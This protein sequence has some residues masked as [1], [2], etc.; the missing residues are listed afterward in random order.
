VYS[1]KQRGRWLER[2]PAGAS[3][4][5]AELLHDQLEQLRGL[6]RKARRELLGESRKQ[7]VAARLREIPGLGPVRVALLIAAMQTP[8][9]FRT[10]RK[11]W[12]Y[13]GLGL[14][15]KGS[16]EYR[17]VEGRAVRRDRA[18]HPRG[19]N[20][21]HRPGLKEIFKSAALAAIRQPGPFKDYYEPRV[22]QGA[23][24]AILRVSVARKLAALTL[25]LWKKGGRY[26]AEGV[27]QA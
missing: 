9:R 5:R 6:R 7:Q 19:L 23:N 20:R 10:R 18:L 25:S 8:H 27:K 11:L 13:A 21:N 17:L 3:R 14:V 16:S 1:R 15:Q 4:T 26:R 22:Q 2:L 12:T 24:P